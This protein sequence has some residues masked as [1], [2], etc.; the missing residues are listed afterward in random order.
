LINL[1]A[2]TPAPGPGPLE[3]FMPCCIL[4]NGKNTQEGKTMENVG[5]AG[6]WSMKMMEEPGPRRSGPVFANAHV[7]KS[8]W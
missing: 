7:V 4:I 6:A 3:L 1:P 5:R 8:D 2:H